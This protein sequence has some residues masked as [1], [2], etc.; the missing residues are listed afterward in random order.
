M[1]AGDDKGIELPDA[2]HFADFRMV[3]S[4]ETIH[5]GH[6]RDVGKKGV[7]IT[8]QQIHVPVERHTATGFPLLFRTLPVSEKNLQIQHLRQSAKQRSL[9]LNWVTRENGKAHKSREWELN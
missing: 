4:T 9:V 1:P 8:R 2:N 5:A 6:A 3:A 7:A